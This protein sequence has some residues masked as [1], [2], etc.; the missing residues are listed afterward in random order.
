MAL[1][2]LQVRGR[3]TGNQDEKRA[4]LIEAIENPP[5]G[6]LQKARVSLYHYLTCNAPADPLLKFGSSH[7]SFFAFIVCGP[8]LAKAFHALMVRADD[9]HPLLFL[10]DSKDPTV[11]KLREM[12]PV[13]EEKST[14]EAAAAAADD[15]RAKRAELDKVAL[16]LDVGTEEEDDDPLPMWLEKAKKDR[17]NAQLSAAAKQAA[18]SKLRKE[19]DG[20]RKNAAA[21]SRE[22]LE[23]AYYLK[24]AFIQHGMSDPCPW[25]VLRDSK[26]DSYLKM[27]VRRV[28]R[29]AQCV[30]WFLGLAKNEWDGKEIRWDRLGV[31]APTARERLAFFA[32]AEYAELIDT[33][34]VRF[35]FAYTP[36][37]EENLSAAEAAAGKLVAWHVLY[38][39]TLKSDGKGAVI[40]KYQIEGL[41]GLLRFMRTCFNTCEAAN[42]ADPGGLHLCFLPG[43]LGNSWTEGR[44]SIFRCG[45]G[46]AVLDGPTLTRLWKK[47]VS[48][49]LRGDVKIEVTRADYEGLRVD[50]ARALKAVEEGERVAKAAEEGEQEVATGKRQRDDRDAEGE[51]E[52]DG[53]GDTNMEGTNGGASADNGTSKRARKKT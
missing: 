45:A 30:K 28:T 47:M 29:F 26:N 4:K 18:I 48:C 10:L 23:Q 41:C 5:K 9:D 2:L 22:A 46:C 50:V 21:F 15:W 42:A 3:A 13:E 7:E 38:N 27:D 19:P 20:F 31:P 8:H 25:L 51:E 53:D 35:L 11:V 52:E 24:M 16:S 43:R 49:E 39:P 6:E 1:G 34:F 12:I 17:E 40:S 32:M 14:Q 36:A 44:F 37:T 33:I